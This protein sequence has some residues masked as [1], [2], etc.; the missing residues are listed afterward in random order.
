[1]NVQLACCQL[2]PD[3]E[4]PRGNAERARGAIAAAVSGGADIVVVPELVNSGYVFESADEARAAAVAAD[5]ELLRGWA[6]EAARG[7]AMVVGGFCELGDDG[8]V[9]NSSALVDGDGVVAVYRKLHLWAYE[10]RWFARGD[11]PAPVVATRFG[12]IGL[13]VCYDLE[14]P[15]LTR[16]LALAGAELIVLP[17]NWPREPKE[18]EAARGGMPI[19]SM[20]ASCTAYL[21]KVFVAVCDRCGT[22]RGLAFEGGSAIADPRG[23]V[24]AAAPPDGEEHTLVATGDLAAAADKSSGELNDAFSDRR[25][26]QYAAGLSAAEALVRAPA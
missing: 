12:R 10:Q 7:S 25:P 5:G 18:L 9:Y 8:R 26:D 14:F 24:L 3:V 4:D 1:M 21:N 17:T 16:G 11:A 6:R 13:G 20:L 22:E 15:E 23:A 19:L 2:A